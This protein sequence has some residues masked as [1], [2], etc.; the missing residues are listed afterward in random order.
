MGIFFMQG[1]IENLDIFIIGYFPNL[2]PLFT[3]IFIGNRIT[4]RFSLS[5][6]ENALGKSGVKFQ[7]KKEWR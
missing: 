4:D 1:K 5:V 3:G 2:N 7:K 6:M